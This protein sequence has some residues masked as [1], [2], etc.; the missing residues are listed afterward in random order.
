M[1]FFFFCLSSLRCL[2]INV[3]SALMSVMERWGGWPQWSSCLFK[4]QP[5]GRLAPP[6]SEH[7]WSLSLQVCLQTWNPSAPSVANYSWPLTSFNF[8]FMLLSLIQFETLLRASTNSVVKTLSVPNSW[9]PATTTR[10]V[11]WIREAVADIHIINSVEICRPLT[12]GKTC[13]SGRRGGM[14]YE[15]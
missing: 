13:Q 10:E 3:S 12:G 2:V 15:L 9:N 11:C 8:N 7:L 5:A 1:N 6:T 4:A 14:F